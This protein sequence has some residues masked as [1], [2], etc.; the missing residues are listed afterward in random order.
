M[1]KLLSRIVTLTVTLALFVLAS[2]GLYAQI[3]SG[4][5]LGSVVDETGKSVPGAK[6]E[7]LNEGTGT[8]ERTATTGANGDFVFSS[9]T[10]AMYTVRVEA[11]GFQ[12]LERKGTNLS[13]GDRLS[14]PRLSR[15]GMLGQLW[16]GQR[17]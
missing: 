4:T 9:I 14:E 11:A 2:S 17:E 13:S 6:V 3:S 1:S 5:M 15:H 8:I 16:I 12:K 10:P 7:I